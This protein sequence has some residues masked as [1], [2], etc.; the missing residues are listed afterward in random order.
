MSQPFKFLNKPEWENHFYSSQ[1]SKN[2]TLYA[3]LPSG[4]TNLPPPLSSTHIPISSKYDHSS[5]YFPTPSN[6][7]AQNIYAPKYKHAG[8]PFKYN[9]NA[10]S[11]QT[12]Y[13]NTR[14]NTPLTQSQN[15]NSTMG[16][17]VPSCSNLTGNNTRIIPDERA[18]TYIKSRDTVWMDNPAILFENCILLPNS[19]MTNAERFNALTRTIILISCI[20]FLVKCPLWWLFLVAGLMLII[21]LW[22]I[23]KVYERPPPPQPINRPR[24]RPI[25]IPVQP[26]QKPAP[27]INLVPRR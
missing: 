10:Q 12:T 5:A 3:P 14:K 8:D 4:F 26:K 17:S 23:I 24:S 13:P 11:I 20:M 6:C 16:Y 19:T 9:P 2:P 18:Q 7:N 15:F 25:I 21:F 1:Q 22:Y 27:I